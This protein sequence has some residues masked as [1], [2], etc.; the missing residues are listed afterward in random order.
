V[1][2]ATDWRVCAISNL[3]Y[4][5]I[6]LSITVAILRYHPW[7]IDV[8]IRKTLLYTVLTTLLAVL[9]FGSVILLQ[10]VFEAAT[11]QQSQLA[12]VLSML[13]I[14]AIFTF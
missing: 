7:N 10:R 8:I 4:L 6:P 12:I 3:A 2:P 5:L 11:G 9:F 13:A 14:A 1:E